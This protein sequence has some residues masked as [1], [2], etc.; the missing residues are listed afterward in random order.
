MQHLVGLRADTQCF[1]DHIPRRRYNDQSPLENMH[2]AKTFDLMR[3]EKNAFLEPK[4]VSE[5]RGVL[6]RAVLGTDMA[7]HA[8]MLTKLEALIDNLQNKDEENTR[9]AT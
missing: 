5:I 6:I 4:L 2:L 1:H 3:K 8:E 9:L 7:K